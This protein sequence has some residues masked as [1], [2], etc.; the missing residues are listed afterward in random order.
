MY[1]MRLRC[2][3]GT[4]RKRQQKPD[5]CHTPPLCSLRPRRLHLAGPRGH[6]NGRALG[7][8]LADVALRLALGRLG[9]RLGLLGLL[10]RRRRLLLLLALLDGLGASRRPGLRP[11]RAALLDHIERGADDGALRLDG[12]AGALL[13]YFLL[14]GRTSSA[15]PA[16]VRLCGGERG[17]RPSERVRPS[18]RG[19]DQMCTSRVARGR[20]YLRDALAVLSSVQD[21]PRDAARVLSL[22]EERLR[23]AV[24]E[25]EHLAIAADVDFSLRDSEAFLSAKHSPPRSCLRAL[26]RHTRRGA[27]TLRPRRREGRW[28]APCQG[29]SAARKRCRRRYASCRCGG[30]GWRQGVASWAEGGGFWRWQRGSIGCR[31]T[32]QFH[33]LVVCGAAMTKPSP[34]ADAGS[35]S[36]SWASRA[37]SRDPSRRKRRPCLAARDR[38]RRKHHRAG[39]TTSSP[40]GTMDRRGRPASP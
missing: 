28:A 11:H 8:L 35:N 15:S 27:K 5:S 22:Q 16:R 2:C 39:P 19:R 21:G 25:S 12:S 24:L 36:T 17:C 6:L 1:P 13:G 9:G 32:L 33:E 37:L 23:L 18:G 30:A 4:G 14:V 3:R 26:S 10:G 29:K 31:G 40:R 34:R 7:H 38:R 20:A